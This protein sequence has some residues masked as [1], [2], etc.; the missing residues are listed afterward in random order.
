MV[1]QTPIT[2]DDMRALL[3]EASG[4]MV[5]EE[6]ALDSALRER[7]RA[8]GISV[9]DDMRGAEHARLIE[10]VRL[11][12]GEDSAQTS[13][14]LITG[15]RNSRGLGDARYN[16]LLERTALLRALSLEEARITEADVRLAYERAHGTRYGVR[17]ITTDE[18]VDGESALAR[19]G[20][21]EAFGEV[22][23]RL[24]T[25]ESAARGGDIG[26]LSAG[27][28]TLP[29]VLREALA[30]LEEGQTS[31]VLSLGVGYA[32]VRVER[33]IPGDGV[34]LDDVR[35]ELEREARERYVERRMAT[36]AREILESARVTTL[37]P[38]LGWSWSRRA[39]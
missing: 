15:L 28:T 16:A 27:D 32:I 1:G 25:H 34:E 10:M 17:L 18:S 9:D 21:G 24:S 5:L 6:L 39:R 2:L 22:A 3:M 37:D 4:A 26:L 20:Q 30:S 8:S 14:E 35:V 29:S 19:L 38:S 23:A 7:A 33:I 36:M 12:V 31:G 13:A 11:Q